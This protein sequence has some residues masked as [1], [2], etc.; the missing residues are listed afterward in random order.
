MNQPL[1]F[2]H[3]VL[4]GLLL[5]GGKVSAHHPN[6]GSLT[7]EQL[8]KEAEVQNLDIKE[9]ESQFKSSEAL[10]SSLNGRLMPQLSVEGGP[11]TTKFDDEKNSG[12]AVYGRAEW[13]LYRGGR[14]S[15][16]LD[17]AKIRSDLDRKKYEA[18]KSKVIR[19]VSRIYYELLFFLEGS[20][21]KQKAIE[22]NQ[23]QMKLAKLK[24]SSGFTSSADVIEFELRE[25]T[26]NSDLKML[27]QVI[28]E[29]SRELSVLLGRSDSSIP[30]LVKGHLTRESSTTLN[31]ENVLS[32]LNMSNIEIAESQA[33]LKLS[34]KDAAIAR[35]GYLPSLDLE[36]KYGKIGNEEKIFAENNNYSVML[37]LSVPLFSGFETMNQTKS[38]RSA[39]VARN[40]AA[41]RK[42]LLIIAE[43]ENLFSQLSTLT[44]RLNLEEKNL[45]K[46]EDYYKI[47]L[48]EYRRGV[49][50]S[51][52]MVG[53]SERLLEARIRNLEYRKD[54]YL[55]KLKIYEL[56]SSD[57]N[58]DEISK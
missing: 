11:L 27:T 1:C 53:A 14:D 29:K 45:S 22:M 51:P 18:V 8:L 28:T 48:G 58:K 20:D 3:L 33:E 31:K 40:T 26:L 46:S 36:A 41:S 7:L 42:T 30:N 52:D 50:N 56:V 23:E 55:T 10:A 44:D 17:K 13:N 24:K 19:E 6:E 4:V 49:K 9:A 39:V 54:Y 5:L 37:K 35:S 15:S 16:E 25:A 21:L 47:T 34:E 32:R 12:T 2:R 57:P 38:A 43:T